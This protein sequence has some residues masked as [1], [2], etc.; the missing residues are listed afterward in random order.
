MGKENTDPKAGI[1]DEIVKQY[2]TEVLHKYKDAKQYWPIISGH[3]VRLGHYAD[4]WIFVFQHTGNPR[5]GACGYPGELSPGTLGASEINSTNISRVR[6]NIER[7]WRLDRQDGVF[8]VKKDMSNLDGEIAAMMR[9]HEH[10]LGL[11]PAR[12]FLSHKGIDKPR[13]REFKDVLSLLGFDPW[14]D[15]DALKAGDKLERALVN[16]FKESCAAVFFITPHFQDEDYLAS[17][18]EYAIAEKREKG[19]RFSIVTLVFEANG[20]KGQVPDLLK[21]YVWKEPK[22]DLEALCEIIIALPVK[23]GDVCWK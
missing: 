14:L 11:G 18:V 9:K 2:E 13:V 22:T 19:D 3:N 1:A 7:H 4:Y 5:L 12:I 15:E 8:I 17:E 16:G 10:A 23:V 20:L 21:T 6:A